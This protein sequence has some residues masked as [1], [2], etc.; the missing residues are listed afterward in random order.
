[1]RVIKHFC[2]IDERDCI[3][4]EFLMAN[5]LIFLIA[6]IFL[7]VAAVIFQ[8][9]TMKKMMAMD[10]F[11]DKESI[12][13]FKRFGIAVVLGFLSTLSGILFIISVIFNAIEHF[14]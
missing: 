9:F 1:M 10:V 13:L 11:D 7:F 5:W 8:L 14:S 4:I 3:M 12:S 6:T 2:T